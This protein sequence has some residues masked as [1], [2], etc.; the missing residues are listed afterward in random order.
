VDDAAAGQ[1][2]TRATASAELERFLRAHWGVRPAA[3]APDLGGSVNL[4]LLVTGNRSL[5]VARVC[6]PFVT[7]QRVA[8]LQAVRRRLARHGVPRAGPVPA[9]GGRGRE[10]FHGRAVEVEPFVAA[11][12]A[13]HAL[14]RVRTGLA[15]PGRI[16]ALLQALP[17]GPAAAAPRF[18]SY[19][20]AAGLVQ[21]AAAGTRRIRA[22]RPAP[23]QAGWPASPT[24]S[25][26]PSPGGTWT[27]PSRSAASWCTATSGTTTPGSAAGRSPWSPTSTSPGTARGQMISRSRRIT[28]ASTSPASPA[29]RRSQPSWPA[30]M[31]QDP[32]PGYP[33]TKGPPSR[34]PWRG[35]RRGP[36]RA[37]WP[38]STTKTQPAAI[39]LRPGPTSTGH[40][41]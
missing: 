32:A 2:G 21:A 35:S 38:S 37:G 12:A 5:Q 8:V 13:M 7:G 40:R 30:P 41:N 33:R 18:A 25:P 39:S 4:N 11:P 3:A 31:K 17:A 22:W 34:A 6:R 19:V 10:T 29:T 9:L 16:H 24:G 36:S 23:P 20:A 15:V 1:R 27:A 28:P 26:A 14:A